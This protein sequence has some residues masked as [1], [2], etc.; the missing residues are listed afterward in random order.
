[1]MRNNL[2]IVLSKA[3]KSLELINLIN[4]NAIF[5]KLRV[6]Y[7]IPAWLFSVI[8]LFNICVQLILCVCFCFYNDFN[9]EKS[10]FAMCIVMAII[11]ILS[12][13]FGMLANIDRINDLLHELQQLVNQSKYAFLKN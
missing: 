8:Y 3:R 9:L 11:Q 12:L 2:F 5:R 6:I 7:D 10:V 4:E 13:Y 1:M